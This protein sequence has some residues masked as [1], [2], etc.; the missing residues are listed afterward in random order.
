MMIMSDMTTVNGENIISKPSY[1]EKVPSAIINE[2]I[3]RM[4]LITPVMIDD[5]V[6]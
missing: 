1:I 5:K 4:K 3:A 2:I 6:T